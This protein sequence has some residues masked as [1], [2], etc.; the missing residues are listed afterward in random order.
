MIIHP[1]CDTGSSEELIRHLGSGQHRCWGGLVVSSRLLPASL[2]LSVK[3][4]VVLTE[5]PRP[6]SLQ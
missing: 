6:G 4:S 5:G 2:F 3:L 1:S